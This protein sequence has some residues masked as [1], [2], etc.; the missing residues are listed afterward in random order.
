MIRYQSYYRCVLSNP[1]IR[2]YH[3]YITMVKYTNHVTSQYS[4]Y[5]CVSYKLRSTTCW[6]CVHDITYKVILV[7]IYETYKHVKRKTLI[8]FSTTNTRH[9]LHR[10]TSVILTLKFILSTGPLKISVITEILYSENFY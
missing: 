3:V 7:L 2:L 1:N 5:R 9:F 8:F 4:K 10:P 6:Y